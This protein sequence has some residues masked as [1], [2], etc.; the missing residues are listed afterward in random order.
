MMKWIKKGLIFKAEG[1]CEWM[2]SHTQ[3]PFALNFGDFI[4]VYFS[5]REDYKD[6][7]CRAFGGFVDLDKSDLKRVLNVS[8]EPLMDLGGIGEFDEFG[9]MPASVIRQNSE[10]Y[11]YYAGWSRGYSVPYE[12]NIGFAK[13]K[14]GKKFKKI[15]KGPLVGPTLYEPYLHGCPIVYKYS[16]HDWHMFYLSGVQWLKTKAK[17]E[18]QYLLMH[19]ASKDGMNWDRNLTPIIETRVEFESQTCAAVIEFN[20]KYHIF[21]SYRHGLDFRNSQRG[22]RMGYA[23]ST[24]LINWTRDDSK[25]GIDVSES[26]WDSEMICY[27]YIIELDGKYIMLYCGNHFGR[28]GFGYAELEM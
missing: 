22:Y 24:D 23:Y 26:G 8:S 9:S 17:A 3:C 11:L 7:M 25:A 5:T 4:R 15:G 28:D 18:S 16:E 14:E 2:H 27:P 19:A 6:G 13:S 1:Q 12:M 10:Y 21:F 20:N